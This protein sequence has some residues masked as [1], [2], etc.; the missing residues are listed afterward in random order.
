[1]DSSRALWARFEKSGKLK[2]YLS[3]CEARRRQNLRPPEQ[4]EG[5]DEAAPLPENDQSSL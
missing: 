5:G 4:N 2:D 1:M 3:F